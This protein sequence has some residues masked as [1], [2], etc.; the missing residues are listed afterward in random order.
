MVSGGN[1]SM[2]AAEVTKALNIPVDFV[3]HCRTG[4]GIPDTTEYV[5]SMAEKYGAYIEESAGDKYEKYVLRKG[6]FGRG[7][8]AHTYAYHLLKSQQFRKAISRHIRQRKRNRTVLLLNGVRVDESENRKYNLPDTINIDPSS[9]NNI[10]V[11]IIHHWTKQD[12]TDFLDS[13]AIK[14]NPVMQKLCRSG[15]CMCG[16]M[17]EPAARVE[18]SYYYP[19]WGAWLDEL[20][21]RV[22]QD[23]PWRWG[24]DIPRGW[25]QEQN[26]Q[27]QLF[28]DFQPAC[29]SCLVGT[30]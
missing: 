13:C 6:F 28:P 17:Q 4:T 24:E 26:G 29:Q 12:C 7:R 14:R 15:E 25:I 5:R 21:S 10:W 22:I 9:K 23:F 1:D 19:E 11:N 3:I 8:I 20:E 2:T 27:L 18:A 30:D 16:T